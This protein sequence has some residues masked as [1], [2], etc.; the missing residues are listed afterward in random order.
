MSLL[1]PVIPSAAPLQARDMSALAVTAAQRATPRDQRNPNA[2]RRATG[3]GRN[4]DRAAEHTRPCAGNRQAQPPCRPTADIRCEPATAYP[5]NPK[6]PAGS[7]SI[8]GTAG[9]RPRWRG[10]RHCGQER[11]SRHGQHRLRAT[12]TVWRICQ[13]GRQDE[14]AFVICTRL[15]TAGIRARRAKVVPGFAQKR[16]AIIKG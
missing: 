2:G 14:C 11:R 13:P 5:R 16:R 1:P 10:S 9:R 4:P 8:A 7:G 3:Q 12:S 15:T 6:R